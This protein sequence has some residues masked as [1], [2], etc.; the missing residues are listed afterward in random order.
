MTGVDLAADVVTRTRK[1][2]SSGRAALARLMGSVVEVRSEGA[3]VIDADGRRHLDFGGYGVFILGHCHPAVVAAVQHQVATHP[4][5]TRTLL[6][7]VIA[8]AAEALAGIAPP[9]LDHV[10]FV[11]SGTEA[12]EAAL[13]LARAHGHHTLIT[14]TGGF[15]GKTL[16]A[17]SVTAN[18]TY[19]DQFRPLL[20][21]VTVV[22]FGDAAAMSAAIA[23]AG[24]AACVIIEPV[25][26]E[27]GVIIPPPGYLTAVA[28]ACAEHGAFL[29]V[30][31]I[32]T[33]LGRLGSWWGIDTERVAPDVLLVGKGL[34]GGIIPVAAMLAGEQTYGPFN[35]DPFLHSSTF[36]GSPL[37]GAAA[38]A[39]VR[40]MAAED[41]PGRAARLGSRLLDGVRARAAA[42]GAGLVADVRG[43]GL[44]IGI[45]MADQ[46]HLGELALALIDRGVLVSHS[47]NASRVIRLTPPAIL[48][49]PELALFFQVFDDALASLTATV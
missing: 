25:Q 49:D 11:N 46:R 15:H 38:L 4:L 27:G 14:T 47:L 41:I 19:Q 17:L 26:G 5:A 22:P 39:A 28:A 44:L 31:E 6:E 43:R 1:H 29:I 7:P 16:G 13:K 3:W 36:G 12:T 18:P 34:S 21:D 2:L 9:G 30:D 35:R 10:H 32:Q 33:G 23:A 45:E 42:H 8:Q 24:R 37:A 40:T 48:G 20:P